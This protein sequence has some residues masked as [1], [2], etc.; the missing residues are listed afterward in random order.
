MHGVVGS[1]PAG[2]G[3]TTTTALHEHAPF[4]AIEGIRMVARMAGTT[5]LIRRHVRRSWLGLVPLAL[6]VAAGGAASLVAF[7]AAHRTATA[8]SRY[9]DR[10]EVGDLVL[11]PSLNTVEI[12]A[13]IRSLPGVRSVHTDELLFATP[14]D[15]GHPRPFAA[16]DENNSG[17]NIVGSV[18]GR[19][20]AVDRPALAEGRLPTGPNEVLVN[21]EAA[22]ERGINV[23]DVVPMAFWSTHDGIA[24][25]EGDP[26]VVVAPVGVEQLT[27]VGIATLPDEVLPDNRYARQ[28]MVV[29][30]DVAARYACSPELVPNADNWE[31]I[32]A[33]L[34]PPGCSTSY[35]F[36]S[37]AVDGG[38]KGIAAAGDAFVR[39]GSE[40]N[41]ALPQAL[42]ERGVGYALLPT[43]TAQGRDRIERS[44]QPTVA[45]FTVLG[46]AAAAV[47]AVIAALAAARGLLTQNAVDRGTADAEHI[48]DLRDG[49][50]LLVVH[51]PGG[52]DLVGGQDRRA[53]TQTATGSRG[54]QAGLRT[55]PDQVALELRQRGEQ[56]DHQPAAGGGGVD[57]LGQGPEP[58]PFV[59]EL[60]HRVEQMTDRTAQPIQPP[61]HHSVPGTQLLAEPPHLGTLVKESRSRVDEDHEA[62]GLLQRI[63]LQ[64]SILI[65]RGDPGI[66]QQRATHVQQCSETHPALFL[67]SD[68]GTDFRDKRPEGPATPRADADGCVGY[69]PDLKR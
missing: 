47:T 62:P 7:G 17:G 27:V 29:S 69:V 26:N 51:A 37:L 54:R 16:I 40:L 15:D 36:Y 57:V 25:Q 32:A 24:A 63:H 8:Y 2:R 55:I 58:H 11:N 9:L 28:R 41:D 22:A 31:D 38:A 12:D 42:Q 45:A 59:L 34:F 68:F 60:G 13:V 50:V 21:A 18:D 61:D 4:R 48:T 33:T 3:G 66:P 20:V 53:P 23:G 65:G 44:T 49:H 39:R 30:P 10:A 5:W 64:R 67:H 19:H 1:F 46:A 35:R 52:L 43:T 14:F 56:V 6:I